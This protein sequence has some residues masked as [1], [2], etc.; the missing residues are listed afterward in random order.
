MD[1]FTGVYLFNINSILMDWMYLIELKIEGINKMIAFALFARFSSVKF[2]FEFTFLFPTLWIG[3]TYVNRLVGIRMPGILQ[4]YFRILRHHLFQHQANWDHCISFVYGFQKRTIGMEAKRAEMN[5]NRLKRNL[6]SQTSH[7]RFTF[8]AL[9][10]LCLAFFISRRSFTFSFLTINRII[11]IELLKF[12]NDRKRS[13][14][15]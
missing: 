10:R 14:S 5:P 7:F 6:H 4:I 3:K 2:I 12:A 13:N 9:T 8:N 11:L 15:T 1:F